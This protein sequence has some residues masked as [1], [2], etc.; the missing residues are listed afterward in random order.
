MLYLGLVVGAILGICISI[1]LLALAKEIVV[2]AAPGKDN[3]VNQ[4]DE[5]TSPAFLAV[6]QQRKKDKLFSE[7][8]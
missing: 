5:Q 2:K 1:I 7:I 6:L 3:V 8:S 4:T